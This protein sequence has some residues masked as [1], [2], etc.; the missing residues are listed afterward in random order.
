M[1]TII[2]IFVITCTIFCFF[3]YLFQFYSSLSECFVL[4]GVARRTSLYDFHIHNGARMVSFAGWEMPVQYQASISE[5]HLQVCNS[6]FFVSNICIYMK[7]PWSSVC[8][9]SKHQ[10]CTIKILQSLCVSHKIVET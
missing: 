9:H 5:E 4:Q 1:C 8:K 10:A 3:E 7:M 2:I 6:S